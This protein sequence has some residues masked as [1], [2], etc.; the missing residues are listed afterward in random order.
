MGQEIYKARGAEPLSD[1]DLSAGL[2]M[3]GAGR[4]S[5]PMTDHEY[6]RK[7]NEIKRKREEERKVILSDILD[8]ETVY[9]FAYVPFVIAEL[10]WD[11][12]DTVIDYAVTLKQDYTKKL[13]R[14]VREMRREYDS[15]RSPYIDALH[16]QSE[17]ENMYVFEDGV[18]ENINLYL[19][20]LRGD[21]KRE[22]PELEGDSLRFLEAVYLCHVTLAS[23]FRYVAIQTGKVENIAGKAIG[24]ILPK[25]LS[26]LDRTILK[27]AGNKPASESFIK[28]QEQY[29]RTF[30]N[31]MCEIEFNEVRD[32]DMA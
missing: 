17:L 8:D 23:L 7:V 5:A 21:L 32:D 19:I 9:R 26:G 14:E 1:A 25:E 30:A 18:R 31:Q 22:Y 20:N 10:A 11:Y 6:R 29:V 13:C 15:F 24:G 27:F 12:A 2:R 4:G 3:L 28:Q 16:R